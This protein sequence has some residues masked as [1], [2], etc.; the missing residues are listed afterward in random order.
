LYQ[1]VSVE[2]FEEINYE[3]Q[4]TTFVVLDFWAIYSFVDYARK[5]AFYNK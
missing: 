5:Y 1:V 3:N 2:H 4:Q